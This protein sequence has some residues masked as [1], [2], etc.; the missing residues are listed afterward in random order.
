MALQAAFCD[1]QLDVSG[2]SPTCNGTWVAV[3]DAQ[4]MSTAIENVV[5]ALNELFSFDSVLFGLVFTGLLLMWTTGHILGRMMQAW[6]KL[7]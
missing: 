1:G 4:A 2:P 6:R 7:M 5:V 3:D